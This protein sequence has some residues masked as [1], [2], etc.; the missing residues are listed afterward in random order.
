MKGGACARGEK[1]VRGPNHSSALASTRRSWIAAFEQPSFL[2]NESN[3]SS[4]SLQLVTKLVAFRDLDNHASSDLRVRCSRARCRCWLC[5]FQNM[6]RISAAPRGRA[7]FPFGCVWPQTDDR[8]AF[9]VQQHQPVV[10]L[11]SSLCPV[12]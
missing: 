2:L 11:M 12:F 10:S 9:P 1:P 8:R 3:F 5:C 6:L 7:C 4:A